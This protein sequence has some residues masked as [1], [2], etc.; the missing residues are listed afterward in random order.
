M[1]CRTLKSP[2]AMRG[3][4]GIVR[5]HAQMIATEDTGLFDDRYQRLIDPI[6]ENA[7]DGCFGHVEDAVHL[8][9]EVVDILML[10]R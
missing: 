9:D 4:R 3:E 1:I 6:E 5:S 8:V 2:A 7:G 10:Q